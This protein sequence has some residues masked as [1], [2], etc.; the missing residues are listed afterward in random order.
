MVCRVR[1]DKREEYLA[2]HRDVWQGVEATITQCGIRNFSIYVIEDVLFGY[3]E[4][5]GD[6]FDAD[7]RR[8]AAD[9]VT[10]EWLRAHLARTR[11]RAGQ[12]RRSDGPVAPARGVLAP[13]VRQPWTRTCTCGSGPSTHSRGST[14]TDGGDRPGLPA[15][16]GRRRALGARRRGLRRRAGRQRPLGDRRPARGGPGLGNDPGRRRLDRPHR[17]RPGADP[18]AARVA[19]RRPAR[20]DPPRHVRRDGRAV[21]RARRRPSEGC[22]RSATPAWCSTC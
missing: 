3:Y 2:L 17:R 22:P 18:D 12:R 14:P 20:G 7:Q 19:G 5:I 1:P 8:M 21:A 10:Q 4:Y 13:T 11:P 9:P 16:R 15:R 6:D